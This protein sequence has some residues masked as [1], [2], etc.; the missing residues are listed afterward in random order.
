MSE[1]ERF[2]AV[3]IGAGGDKPEVLID[4]GGIILTVSSTKDQAQLMGKYL[5][6]KV[7][8]TID[9]STKITNIKILE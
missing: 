5:Y 7:E 4:V 6:K 8:L 2:D 9:K 1:F 3:V